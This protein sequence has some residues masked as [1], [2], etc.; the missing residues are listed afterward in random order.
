M[1]KKMQPKKY[2]EQFRQKLDS[3]LKEYDIKGL[4]ISWVQKHLPKMFDRRT[5]GK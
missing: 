5:K 4:D 3:L 1:P 2:G